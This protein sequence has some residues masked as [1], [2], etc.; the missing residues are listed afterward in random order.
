MEQIFESS[1]VAH[2][3]YC[4]NRTCPK[5]NIPFVEVRQTTQVRKHRYNGHAYL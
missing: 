5:I 1:K 2:V 3:L 4:L